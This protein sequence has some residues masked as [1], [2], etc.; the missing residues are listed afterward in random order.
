MT[1]G[2][3]EFGKILQDCHIDSRAMCDLG[4]GPAGNIA[5]D[6]VEEYK[7]YSQ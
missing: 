1:D 5:P 6:S 4:Q 3:N 2:N 7:E